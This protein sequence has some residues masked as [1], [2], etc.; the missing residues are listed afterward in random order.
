MAI[1]TKKTVTIHPERK[2]IFERPLKYA[3]CRTHKRRG[4]FPISH[5]LGSIDDENLRRDD[6]DFSSGQT[7]KCYIF[8]VK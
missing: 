1:H 2:E 6:G 3:E 7:N 4:Q 5:T 8:F